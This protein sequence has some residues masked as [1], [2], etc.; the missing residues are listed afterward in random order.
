MDKVEEDVKTKDFMIFIPD[1]QGRVLVHPNGESVDL[2]W[3]G[4]GTRVMMDREEALDW[5][6]HV[7][8]NPSLGRRFYVERM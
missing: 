6:T 8:Y 1:H 5:I 7:M 3:A 4:R 2:P